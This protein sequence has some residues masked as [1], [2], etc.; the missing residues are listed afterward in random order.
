LKN[1]VA[2]GQMMATHLDTSTPGLPEGYLSQAE[3]VRL[4]QLADS[5]WSERM[6]APAAPLDWATQ[7][8]FFVEVEQPGWGRI[9]RRWRHLRILFYRVIQPDFDFAARFKMQHK[10]QAR[11][12]RPIRLLAKSFRTS[13]RT[14]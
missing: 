10:W 8:R 2:L 3:C 7:H 12:L 14:A 13:S 1:I 5:L 4:K 11:L 6:E 9:T